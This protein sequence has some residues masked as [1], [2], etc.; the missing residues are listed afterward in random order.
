MDEDITLEVFACRRNPRY[1]RASQYMV[2]IAP[3]AAGTHALHP[4]RQWFQKAHGGAV[5]LYVD[6]EQWLPT[7]DSV[8]MTL[9]LRRVWRD[10]SPVESYLVVGWK[11]LA[12]DDVP[13]DAAATV[14]PRRL[15]PA[16]L[17]MP[18]PQPQQQSL[19]DVRHVL[20]T[21]M[22]YHLNMAQQMLA[23]LSML[24]EQ[25]QVIQ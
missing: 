5:W 8:A 20:T 4:K 19:A 7:G 11:L 15:P 13:E 23:R 21:Y 2:R 9:A 10:S 14:D 22:H 1:Q 6:T 18:P 25:Q 24:N 16:A 12:Q 3:D 17:I